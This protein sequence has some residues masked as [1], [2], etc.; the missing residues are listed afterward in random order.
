MTFDDW[1]ENPER[2]EELAALVDFAKQEAGDDPEQAEGLLLYF[3]LRVG[4]ESALRQH[5]PMRLSYGPHG[6][7]TLH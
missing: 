3:A 5:G 1:F 2:G 7:R 4:W 6:A